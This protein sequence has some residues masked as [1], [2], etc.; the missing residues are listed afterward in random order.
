M[1][2]EILSRQRWERLAKYSR[3]LR[4]SWN[5][6]AIDVGHQFITEFP[7]GRQLYN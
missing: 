6:E 1:E 5:S 2:A 4:N 7:F 3:I